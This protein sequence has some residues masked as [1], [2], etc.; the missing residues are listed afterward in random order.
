MADCRLSG[1]P[2][3][4]GGSPT[5]YETTVLVRA[6][7]L[8]G[9]KRAKYIVTGAAPYLNLIGWYFALGLD[10]PGLRHDRDRGRIRCRRAGGRSERRHGASGNRGR[11]SRRAKSSCAG[12]MAAGIGVPDK[13]AGSRRWLAAYGDVGCWTTSFLKI[14]DHS[15]TSSS[16]SAREISSESESAQ[17]QPL[18]RRRRRDRGSAVPDGLIMIDRQCCQI[19]SRH[20]IPFTFRGLCRAPGV[21]ADPGRE[22]SG[23]RA[24]SKSKFRLID[25]Q[26][27]PGTRGDTDHK[28]KRDL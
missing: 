15:K 6:K 20:D 14:V 8:I 2:F 23:I 18:Y 28:L 4:L 9:M 1:L 26:L 22:V 10:M 3:R 11:I 25:V 17:V 12:R 13:T 27:T 21:G 5:G 19:R 24:S 7:Q 16:P